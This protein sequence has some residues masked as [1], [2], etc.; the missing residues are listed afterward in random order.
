MNNTTGEVTLAEGGLYV[1]NY[2][3]GKISKLKDLGHFDHIKCI[4]FVFSSKVV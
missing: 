4:F 3:G 1:T 2:C